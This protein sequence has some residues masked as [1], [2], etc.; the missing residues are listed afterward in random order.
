MGPPA[1]HHLNDGLTLNSC[2]VALR[3]FRGFGPVLLRKHI[4]VIFGGGGGRGPDPCAPLW[5]RPCQSRN[6]QSCPDV[7]LVEPV[8]NRVY[9]VL[10]K[11]IIWCLRRDSNQ[12]PLYLKSST[13]PLVDSTGIIQ[14]FGHCTATWYAMSRSH[15]KLMEI[16]N[17]CGRG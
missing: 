5:I 7:S 17:S 3:F 10:H 16:G 1:K 15:L 11:E 12:R 9:W 8:L 13:L 6:F 14:L 4:F 2:L